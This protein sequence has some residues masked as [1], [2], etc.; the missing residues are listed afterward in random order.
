MRRRQAYLHALGLTAW[1]RRDVGPADSR[2]GEAPESVPSP[3]P[4]AAPRTEPATEPTP[5]PG[6]ATPAVTRQGVVLEAGSGSCLYLC[7]AGDDTAGDLASDLGRVLPKA[8]VW[9]RL[10]PEGDGV[11]LEAA[12]AERLFTHVVVF[13]EAQARLVFDGD[14]PERLGPARITVA[15]DL[16]RLARDAEA[17][18][19]CWFALRSAGCVTAP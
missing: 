8:P 3:A 18:K 11:P 1:E 4:A 19:R 2:Q 17:R 6:P 7:G 15:P 16:G 5:E 12:I 9:G 10:D 14:A 13:G